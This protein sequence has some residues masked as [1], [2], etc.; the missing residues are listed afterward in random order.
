MT[1]VLSFLDH[2]RL[3]GEKAQHFPPLKVTNTDILLRAGLP[4]MCTLPRQ[5][6][7]RW[8]GYVHRMEDDRIPKMPPADREL[9]A[10]Q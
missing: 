3:S 4:T 6:L 7:L 2:L 5:H 9:A 1:D 8:L 10:V